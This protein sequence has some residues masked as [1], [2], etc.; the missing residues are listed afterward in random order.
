M[1]VVPHVSKVAT[2]QNSIKFSTLWP[3]F[4]VFKLTKKLVLTNVNLRISC[5]IMVIVNTLLIMMTWS[6]YL[7]PCCCRDILGNLNPMKGLLNGPKLMVRKMYENSLNMEIITGGNFEQWTLLPRI[8][9]SPS[10]ATVPFPFKRKQFSIKLAFGITINK[11]QG[12]T[13]D[14]VGVYLPKP[15]FSHAKYKRTYKNGVFIFGSGAI[16]DDNM[17]TEVLNSKCIL[18]LYFYCIYQTKNKKKNDSR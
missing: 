3:L 7:P 8:D 11:A 17:Y 2:V 4:K 9:L 14:W 16:K 12:W 15:V 6:T 13:I 10:D 5:L 1:P 18:L